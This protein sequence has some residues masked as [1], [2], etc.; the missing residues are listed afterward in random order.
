MSAGREVPAGAAGNPGSEPLTILIAALG[1]QGGGVLTDWLGE[2]AR[3][4]GLAVQATSTPGVSQ[5]TGATGYYVELADPAA[6]GVALALA[7]LPG[8][9]DVLVCAELLEAARMLER[10]MCTPTRTVV[11]ASTHRV[12][13]TREKMSGG[14]ARFDDARVSA[15]LR[16]LSRRA[17]LLDMEAV[18]QRHRAAISAVLFGALAGSGAVPLPRAACEAAIAAAGKGVRESLAAF[19]EAFD[20]AARD[21][22]EPDRASA[23]DASTPQAA[24]GDFVPAPGNPADDLSPALVARLAT[25]PPA[26]A[27]VASIGA[28]RTAAF[29]DDAYAQRYVGRVARVAAAAKGAD[30]VAVEAART[31]A[32]WMCYDDVIRVATAKSRRSRLDRIRDG[33][34]SGPGDVVRIHD[35]FKP[36]AAEIAAV[37]P[38]GIGRLVER[39]GRGRGFALRLNATSPTGMLALRLLAAMRPLRPWSRRWADEQGAI[40]A[41]LELLLT[42]LAAG[43]ADPA[44]ALEIARLPT[45]A[46]GYGDTHASGAA[47]RDRLLGAARDGTLTAEALRAQFAAAVALPADGGRGARAAA[48]ARPVTWFPSPRR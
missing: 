10:G 11:I 12:Y 25:L 33:A 8:R 16:T 37:L 39:L 2:A 28:A 42:T 41:W 29:Q 9:V 6:A 47:T 30:A 1:G 48:Q 15:A 5:R 21:E 14:D 26:L 38:R 34:G 23:I 20:L 27:A 17:I 40:E 44:L 36:R 18:R 32:L 35:F 45:L 31:L 24:A 13:T 7:P 3:A 4:E 46:R 43:V 19:G 22:S